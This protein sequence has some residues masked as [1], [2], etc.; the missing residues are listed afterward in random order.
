MA[1]NPYESLPIYGT[2]IVQAYNGQDSNNLDPHIYA[3]AEEAFKQMSR[4]VNMIS[5]C[6]FMSKCMS[7]LLFLPAKKLKGCQTRSLCDG[8]LAPVPILHCTQ[9]LELSNHLLLYPQSSLGNTPTD[10]E[11]HMVAKRNQL[12]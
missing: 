11:R 7:K 9:L 5:S 3:V 4:F 1:I 2:E 8:L 10:G 6:R 12:S